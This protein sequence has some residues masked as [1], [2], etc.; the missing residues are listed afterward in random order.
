ML[1]N[2]LKHVNCNCSGSYFNIVFLV[3]T[4]CSG[5]RLNVCKTSALWLSHGLLILWLVLLLAHMMQSCF[6][7]NSTIEEMGNYS[8]S[9]ASYTRCKL[10]HSVKRKRTAIRMRK[11]IFYKCVSQ[12]Q[13]RTLF[14]GRI[15]NIQIHKMMLSI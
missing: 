7:K 10:V 2:V 12:G 8:D 13:R 6:I 3:C 11:Q 14:W 1:V 9:I 5:N 4:H 15:W